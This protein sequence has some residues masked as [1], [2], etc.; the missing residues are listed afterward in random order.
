[1]FSYRAAY[2]SI[3]AI[4]CAL[5]LASCSSAEPSPTPEETFVPAPSSVAQTA[6]IAVPYAYTTSDFDRIVKRINDSIAAAGQNVLFEIQSIP[7]EDGKS[8]EELFMK[9]AKQEL[10]AGAPT[11]DAYL[12]RPD[13]SAK[14]F[15]A[16]LTMDVTDAVRQNAPVFHSK[17]NALFPETLTGIPAGIYNRA[18]WSKTALMLRDDYVSIGSGVNTA[19]GLLSFIDETIAKPKGPYT[20]LAY[21]T[22]ILMQWVVDKGYYMLD[23]FGLSAMMCCAIDDADLT[24]VPI[25]EVPGFADFIQAMKALRKAGILMY[26]FDEVAGKECIAYVYGLS[27][28]YYP[29]PY[30]NVPI[31]PGHFTAQ[32][33]SPEKP[34]YFSIPGYINELAVPRL[35]GADKPASV[36]C[37]I[38][39][40]YAN[41]DN[42]D[43][44][45]YGEKGVD[46]VDEPGKYSPLIGGKPLQGT[47]YKQLDG[48]FF[49][50][51]AATELS[52]FDYY[53][54][55]SSAPQGVDKLVTEGLRQNM[56]FPFMQRIAYNQKNYEKLGSPGDEIQAMSKQRQD[57]LNNLIG[58]D[59]ATFTKGSLDSA[60]ES[61]GKLNN[62]WLCEQYKGLIQSLISQE[63]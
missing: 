56:R 3:A 10:A 50:W 33:F 62:K 43:S 60:L 34:G 23:E 40:M 22:D 5:F 12:L 27:Y 24:P 51:P 15:D 41:Q 16:G 8:D 54:L 61:L 31:A 48:L 4:L 49:T 44:V 11:A 53:R 63:K 59:P 47:G 14:L 39:W 42:Y 38:E 13:Y 30:L 46:F 2:A 9:K 1:M 21:E 25:E 45:I 58:S 36:A 7:R 19:E 52:N 29:S 17:Y 6:K 37:F 26:P 20:V 57:I 35:C 55:P 32:L 18:M 28:Y